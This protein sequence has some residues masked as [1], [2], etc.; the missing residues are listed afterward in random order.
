MKKSLL[1]LLSMAFSVSA[2][3]AVAGCGGSQDSSTPDSSIP[4]S[5]IVVGNSASVEDSN[6][7]E[8]QHDWQETTAKVDAEC[9][10]AGSEAVFTC[11]DCGETKGGEVIE[12]LEHDWQEGEAK[13]EPDCENMGKEAT[14]ICVNGC[15]GE[16]GG[17][18]IAASGHSWTAVDAKDATCTQDG[19]IAHWDC[20]DCD[21]V[22]T[23]EADNQVKV[24]ASSVVL[25]AGHTYATADAQSATCTQAGWEAYE[26][27]TECDYTEK[28]E[29]Y[30]NHTFEDGVCSNPDCGIVVEA[31][32]LTYGD[33]LAGVAYENGKW[34]VTA[35]SG[36][37]LKFSADAIQSY[38][39]QNMGKLVFTFTSK[40]NQESGLNPAYD[41]NH[42]A[43]KKAILT[44]EITEEIA[45]NGLEM[46]VYYSTLG[47][48]ASMDVSDGFVVS[49]DGIVKYSYDNKETWLITDNMDVSYDADKDAFILATTEGARQGYHHP[50]LSTELIQQWK[51]AGYNTLRLT[52]TSLNDVFTGFKLDNPNV[53]GVNLGTFT[54]EIDLYN[55]TSHDAITYAPEGYWVM[56]CYTN[57]EVD[58]LVM[59]LTPFDSTDPANMMTYN[60]TPTEYNAETG[61]WTINSTTTGKILKLDADLIAG[62]KT[63][64]RT[65]MTITFGSKEGQATKWNMQFGGESGDYT[66]NASNATSMSVKLPIEDW[67]LE[68][69]VQ[70][71]CYFYARGFDGDPATPTD[72][73]T[74]SIKA[75][76][77]GSM[78]VN[79]AFNIL[80]TE[81]NYVDVPRGIVTSVTSDENSVTV[82]GTIGTG[83]AGNTFSGFGLSKAAVEAWLDLGF[84]Y[85]TFTME[86]SADEGKTAPT[87]AYIY[88]YN[89]KMN[90]FVSPS[91]SYKP[92][93]SV[94]TIDLE[95]LYNVLPAERPYLIFVFTNGGRW[96]ATGADGYCT[97][98]N[99]SFSA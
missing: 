66:D 83:A 40:P 69:G 84:K 4:D 49:V 87:H 43:N 35:E 78:D 23:G 26:Y 28:Q 89:E 51:D 7:A 55:L 19:C 10:K 91:G 31:T 11:A 94:I 5:S 97:F 20:E 88:D 18:T 17:E 70:F 73:F 90:F 29:F 21:A 41:G 34:T 82:G 1:L 62:Y 56:R 39:D 60:G 96:N 81:A 61:M 85:F 54:T 67:M 53:E 45:R 63:E 37:V 74:V 46:R 33:S 9:E 32:Y 71:R 14:Y 99:V 98:S 93:G 86:L 36:Q 3:A 27:C 76:G 25:P 65:S 44:I 6:S 57:V 58:G 72:G 42:S 13:V 38:V 68:N 50:A 8:C 15:G 79:Q 77:G 48:D 80:A 75:T 30:G 64:G 24:D 22:A 59:K 16:Q 92:D 47:W 52:V 95:A 12:A 2:M